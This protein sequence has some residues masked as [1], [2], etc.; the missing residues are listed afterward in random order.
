MEHE[1]NK[2][3]AKEERRVFGMKKL[4]A[5]SEIAINT[6]V[7]MTKHLGNI[8]LMAFIGAM[9]AIQAGIVASQQPPTY[10]SGGLLGGKSH[11]Q[12]GTIIEA[13]RGEFVVNK[14]SVNAL[15]LPFMNAINSYANGGFIGQVQN[16]A[17]G[18]NNQSSSPIVVNISAPLVDDSV[19]DSI[20]PAINKALKTGRANIGS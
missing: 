11:S 8:P 7:S 1:L 18:M 5:L 19:V 4:S 2:K 10:E 14:R 15:G 6:A 13:E 20:I 16:E 9:G 17:L 12:G 3:F